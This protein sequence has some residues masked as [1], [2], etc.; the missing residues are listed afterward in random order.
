MWSKLGI[1]A[2]LVSILLLGY[3]VL[4]AVMRMGHTDQFIFVPTSLM[5]TFGMEN[6]MWINNIPMGWGQKIALTIV[7]MPLSFLIFCLG[8]SFFFIHMVTD[9]TS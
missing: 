1:G 4:I 6:F 3:N 2:L 5:K 9:N 7:N 8:L